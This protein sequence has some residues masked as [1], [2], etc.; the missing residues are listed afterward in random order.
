MDPHCHECIP[1][2]KLFEAELDSLQK[3][4]GDDV[5][6]SDVAID[7]ANTEPRVRFSPEPLVGL[8]LSGGGIRSATF[9]LGL[10]IGLDYYRVLHFVDYLSTV[11]GGGY[12]GGWLS[13]WH[14]RH[15]KETLRVPDSDGAQKPP[16]FVTCGNSASFSFC[17]WA[18][19]KWI[20]GKGSFPWSE[21]CSS[22]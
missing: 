17:A 19:L 13:A 2:A 5:P 10:L 4:P 16:R 14:G 6:A 12:I 11:S 20:F 9:G 21:A 22:H 1:F 8:A 7:A 15:G 3:R 18:S